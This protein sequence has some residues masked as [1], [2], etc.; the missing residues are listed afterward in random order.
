[1]KRRTGATSRSLRWAMLG[2]GLIVGLVFP[3]LALLL[4]TPKSPVAFIAFM[5]AC[6]AA[7]GLRGLAVLLGVSSRV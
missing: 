1:M 2:G 7:G 3:F 4:V 6:I 5:L